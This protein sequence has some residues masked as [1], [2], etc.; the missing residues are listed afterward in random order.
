[1]IQL[2]LT[3]GFQLLIAFTLLLSVVHTEFL[4]V[5]RTEYSAFM[6]SSKM[7]QEQAVVAVIMAPISEKNKSRKKG[8]KKESVW[9]LGLK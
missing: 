4:K 8:Q 9:K 6:S 2:W 5:V 1:M 3:I 7:I